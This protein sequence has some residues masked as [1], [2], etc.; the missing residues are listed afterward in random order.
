VLVKLPAVPVIVTVAEP[1]VAVPLAVSVKVL[2]PV[3]LGGLKET[4]TPLGNPEADRLTLPLKPFC[5]VTEM[6]LVLLAPCTIDKV[7]G[8]A[9][10]EK[11]GTTAAVTVRE[12]VVELVKVPEVPVIVTPTVPVVAVPLAV[13]VKVLAPVVL[14]GLKEA[15]TPLGNPEAD[16][17]TLPLKP[18][19]GVT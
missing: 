12:T 7:L 17:L 8:E 15:V 19:C 4:V 16:K 9:E 6:V 13:S 5:A 11:L 14:A 1:V 3:V 18:F 10:R 2:V